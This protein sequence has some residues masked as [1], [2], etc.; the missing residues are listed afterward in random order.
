MEK[1][2]K[3]YD[4]EFFLRYCKTQRTN[5]NILIFQPYVSLTSSSGTTMWSP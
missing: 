3:L 2:K 5:E 4:Y 1:K